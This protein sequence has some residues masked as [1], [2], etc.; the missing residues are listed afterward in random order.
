MLKMRWGGP[1]K[2]LMRFCDLLVLFGQTQK[3]ILQIKKSWKQKKFKIIKKINLKLKKNREKIFNIFLGK[4]LI[5][6]KL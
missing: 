1:Q 4:K 6:G 3:Q 2:I 5:F